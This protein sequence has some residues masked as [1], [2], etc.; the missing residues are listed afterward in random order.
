MTAT[1]AEPQGV[2]ARQSWK[3]REANSRP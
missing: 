1:V 3:K 2:A